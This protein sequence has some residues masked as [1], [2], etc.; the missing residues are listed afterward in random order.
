[1]ADLGM[2]GIFIAMGVMVIKGVGFLFGYGFKERNKCWSSENAE[3]QL[4]KRTKDPR[5]KEYFP[6]G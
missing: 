1:M 3:R 4:W 6:E 2:I 5:Y